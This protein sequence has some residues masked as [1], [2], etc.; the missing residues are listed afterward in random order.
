MAKKP[1]TPKAHQSSVKRIALAPDG[2]RALSGGTD[3]TVL[4]WDLEALTPLRQFGPFKSSCSAGECKLQAR[5]ELQ[6][7]VVAFSRRAPLFAILVGERLPAQA[8]DSRK[9][10]AFVGTGQAI[11]RELRRGFERLSLEKS[12]ARGGMFSALEG[13]QASGHLMSE[14]GT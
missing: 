11:G 3:N 12:R 9:P 14:G 7:F 4:L 1:D 2:L 6:H 13:A 5:V 8:R 10:Q